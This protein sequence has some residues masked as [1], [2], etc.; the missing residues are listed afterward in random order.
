MSEEERATRRLDEQNQPK[1][2]PQTAEPPVRQG[3]RIQGQPK[4]RP[5]PAKQP[6]VKESKR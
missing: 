5:A 6:L 2:R 4:E 1:P 3:D